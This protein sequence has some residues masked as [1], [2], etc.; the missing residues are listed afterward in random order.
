M[1]PQLI[2]GTASFGMD[3]TEFQDAD[4]VANI[5]GKLEKLGINRVDTAARYPPP[6]P[7]RSEELIGEA[8]GQLGGLDL[9]LSIDTKVYTNTATDGSGDLGREA[10]LRSLGKS[11]QRLKTQINV[12]YSHRPDPSTPLEEQ[13]QAFN[14]Q[15][16]L[17]TITSWGVA[18]TPLHVLKRVLAICEE[19]GWQKPLCYQGHYSLISRAAEKEL[20]P[21]LR[22]HNMSFV[23]YQILEA[24]FLTG[25]FLNNQHAGTRFD[26]EN[27][28]GKFAQSV[29]A[30]EA[31]HA[32]VKKLDTKVKE[33]GLTM[34]EVAVRLAVHQLA[35][36]DN[37]AVII[38][39]SKAAQLEETV[40]MIRKGPLPA[41]F[42]ELADELWAT[43]EPSRG[44]KI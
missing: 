3:M 18:N 23:V 13:I 17:G 4:S 37:D 19:R 27:P 33:K 38:G 31:L 14:E 41:E 39:A 42:L 25:K 36:G 28:L 21:L 44:N 32:A 5:L 12:L 29:F 11:L 7:G 9:N 10:L 24:G 15:I 34:T 26:D 8:M 20:L 16:E 43:L 35:L 22:R 1:A 2:L 6:R 40:R 30:D